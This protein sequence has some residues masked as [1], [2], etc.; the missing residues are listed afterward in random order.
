MKKILIGAISIVFLILVGLFFYNLIAGKNQETDIESI[1]ADV[2]SGSYDY[3]QGVDALQKRNYPVAEACFLKVLSQ[4]SLNKENKVNT[5]YN[6]GVTYAE[7]GKFDKAK[8]YWEQAA[9][10]GDTA[11]AGELHKLN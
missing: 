2:E 10:M 11:S 5:L 3:K 4:Q 1:K 9:N 7:Q 6:L 8:L